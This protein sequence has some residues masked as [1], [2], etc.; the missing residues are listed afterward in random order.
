M[1]AISAMSQA[2]GERP[3]LV[4][5][6]MIDQL[7]SD[8]IEL[9][10]NHLGENG[11]KRLTRDGACFENVN[12]N[13]D[14]I[15]IVSSTAMLVTGTYPRINGLSGAQVYDAQKRI[16]QNILADPSKMGNFTNEKLSPKALNVSTVS[17]ELK[18][19]GGG[20]GYVYSVAPDA[21]QAIILAGHAGNGAFWINDVNGKWST[22]TFYTDVPQFISNR[23]Y[24]TPL[25][26]RIDTM[27]W[28][29]IMDLAKY[30]DIPSHKK[31]YPFKYIFPASRKDRYENYKRS[32]LV[33]EEVTTV[34]L[35]FLKT[36]N[37]GKRGETDMLNIAYS[38]APYSNEAG[39]GSVELQDKYLRLDRQLGRL[40]DAI[41]SNVGLQNTLVVVSSTGYFEDNTPVDEKYNIPTGV[42]TPSKAKSLLNLYLMA[43]YGN[44][45]WV[46]DYHNECFYLDRK[47]IKEKN[48][49]LQEIRKSASD[50][51]RRMSGVTEAYSIDEIIDNPTGA[52]AQRMRNS[53]VPSHVGDILIKIMPGWSVASNDNTQPQKVKHVR[54]Q[55]VSTPVYILHPAVKA[56][57]INTLI[58]ATLLAP[59]VSRLLRIRSPNAASEKPYILE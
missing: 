45:Q 14:N 11:F 54:A 26:S 49:N 44:A 43:V 27:S 30:P 42:F 15:D 17:D 46:S 59:T 36:L 9:L 23:N 13:I 29:P 57:K 24:K 7:R 52:T 22:T 25:S 50:F 40:L 39:E 1:V 38:L 55:V 8:Y 56:Q 16:A 51:L 20:L 48:I 4:V 21:Q 19:N 32:A 37:M 5:E 58:D 10:Q 2:N 33:N 28:S 12:F 18:I 31:Y 35:D 41:D 53:L 6:I 3:K 34:A 47:L